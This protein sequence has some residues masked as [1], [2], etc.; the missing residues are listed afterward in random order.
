MLAFSSRAVPSSLALPSCP[1]QAILCF[2]P[3]VLS[4]VSLAWKDLGSAGWLSRRGMRVHFFLRAAA[5]G[6]ISAQAALW[7]LFLPSLT[8]QPCPGRR[9]WLSAWGIEEMKLSRSSQPPL[10]CVLD[11]RAPVCSQ[12]GPPV[13]VSP[14][15]SRGRI[16]KLTWTQTGVRVLKPWFNQQ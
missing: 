2:S 16:S 6:R 13:R 5:M 15:N 10:L 9:S 7:L 11:I 12:S 4:C 8:T 3:S 14:S 1:P